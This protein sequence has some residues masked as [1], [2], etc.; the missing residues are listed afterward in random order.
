MSGISAV[1]L[2]LIF[3]MAT[4][5]NK[6]VSYNHFLISESMPLLIIISAAIGGF[7]IAIVA[8]VI[9]MTAWKTSSEPEDGI[10][11]NEQ[12]FLM[13]RKVFIFIAF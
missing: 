3:L 9:A 11:I 2:E 1:S 13:T 8:I 4:R 12:I 6:H 10:G 7:L 5:N